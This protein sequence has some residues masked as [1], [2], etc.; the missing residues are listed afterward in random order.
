LASHR[1]RGGQDDLKCGTREYRIQEQHSLTTHPPRGRTLVHV[2]ARNNHRTTT[3]SHI[4]LNYPQLQ[5]PE[6]VV[7]Q[8]A[9]R[10]ILQTGPELYPSAAGTMCEEMT[11]LE[12]GGRNTH[13][14]REPDQY[15]KQNGG[16]QPLRNNEPNHGVPTPNSREPRHEASTSTQTSETIGP[17]PESKHS[18]QRTRPQNIP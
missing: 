18:Q 4:N 8:P 16:R 14:R 12:E 9:P 2:P 7:P 17:S 10:N 3:Q 13:R 15:R 5:D 11:P 1:H 6:G